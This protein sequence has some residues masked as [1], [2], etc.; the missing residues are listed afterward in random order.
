M[1]R[2]VRRL[3]IGLGIAI[4]LVGTG[5]LAL[6]FIV[7]TTAPLPLPNPNGYDDLLKAGQAV[8]G[9]IDDALDLDHEGL[10]ALVATNAEVLRLLRVGLARQ[11]AVPTEAHIANYETVVSGDLIGLKSLAR[12]LSAEGKLAEMENRWADAA[13]S[14][15]DAAH[16]GR[17]MS[18]GGLM[19]DRLVGLACESVGII[20][21]VKLL[22]KLTCDQMR[23]LAAELEQIDDSTVPWREVLQNENRFARAHMRGFLDPIALVPYW[24]RSRGIRQGVQERHDV[25]AAHLRLLAV[26]LALRSYRCDQGSAPGNL[27]Q[28]VPKY[29]LHMPT[30]PFGDKPLIYRSS[31]TNWV[32]YSLGPDKMDDGGK[33]ADKSSEDSL[34]VFGGSR[35]GKS[36]EKGDLSY[37]SRWKELQRTNATN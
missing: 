29:L 9:N 32:L 13:R 7:R 12:V 23:P 1:T 25:A 17:A 37:D 2:N 27:T 8:A 19:I 11:C 33:P 36:W 20:P 31:G 22:P 10:R 4:G 15:T 26:E 5:V 16:L 35:S 24:W 18:R 6:L 28:L 30:D 21:L 34:L 14:Y 3:L